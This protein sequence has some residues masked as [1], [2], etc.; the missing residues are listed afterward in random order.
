M[1]RQSV[2]F[3]YFQLIFGQYIYFPEATPF[4]N[5]IYAHA[6]LRIGDSLLFLDNTISSMHQFDHFTARSHL[7]FKRSALRSLIICNA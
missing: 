5:Y 1:E 2:S 7:T 6:Y 3:R 4:T